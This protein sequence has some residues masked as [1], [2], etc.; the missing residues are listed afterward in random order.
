MPAAKFVKGATTI[1]FTRAPQR[2]Q[3]SVAL[4]QPSI[5]STGGDRVGGTIYDTDTTIP[6]SWSGMSAADLASLESFFLTTV[7]GM[8]ETF[9]YTD[10]NGTAHTVRF[11]T[12]QIQTREKAYDRFD[13]SLVLVKT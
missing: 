4:L 3:Q 10:T 5:E 9:T 11:A 6:L 12:P 13:V 2:P 8:A 1:T 7:G